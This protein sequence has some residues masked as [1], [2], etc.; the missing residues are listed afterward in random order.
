[1]GSI[2]REDL[3]RDILLT[4]KSTYPNISEAIS[5]SQL[6]L[7][8]WYELFLVKAGDVS[9]FI[10]DEVHP[11]PSPSL[12][13]F[14]GHEIHKLHVKSKKRFERIKLLFNP[15]LAGQFAV[16][17]YDLLSCFT[18]RPKGKGN[19]VTLS[20]QQRAS[21]LSRF[22]SM[23]EA[24][25]SDR[26]ESPLEEIIAFLG[27]LAFVNRLYSEDPVQDEEDPLPGKVEDI[28]AYINAHLDGDLSLET[29][30]TVHRISLYYMCRTFKKKIGCTLHDYILYK[31]ISA[32]KELLEDGVKVQR[33]GAMCGFGS[34][35]R[36]AA[37]FKA[38][39]GSSPTGYAKARRQ[40]PPSPESRPPDGE[41]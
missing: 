32:A 31:R 17:G 15:A 27:L 40:E 13:I 1:M 9:W 28:I 38:I 7:H 34:S 22:E 3:R 29:L 14:N 11:A 20:L 41:C 12:A 37:A 6:L 30:S 25:A 16:D 2:S 18:D 26:P 39:A 4:S 33:V 8:D 19:I 10:E 35:A 5:N 21:L 23:G 36:F 24:I